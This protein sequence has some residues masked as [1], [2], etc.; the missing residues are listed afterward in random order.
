MLAGE[1]GEQGVAAGT[2]VLAIAEDDFVAAENTKLGFQA[3][4]RQPFARAE[5][6]R[7]IVEAAGIEKR[8]ELH[9]EER[10]FAGDSFEI[11]IGEE[12]VPA[13]RGVA[14]LAI[15][16]KVDWIALSLVCLDQG[17][18]NIK[19]VA[20]RRTLWGIPQFFHRAERPFII[21]FFLNRSY[22]H[23]SPF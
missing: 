21:H 8:A 18:K 2:R 11:P 15:V 19:F 5:R 12:V 7:G 16:G 3:S 10:V 23:N 1:D 4:V 14:F 20:L 13:E 6:A 22:F 17:Y 9:G